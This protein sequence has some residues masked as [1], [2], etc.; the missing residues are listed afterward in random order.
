MAE[1]Q[2]DRVRVA[3]SQIGRGVFAQ[4][5]FRK[6][7]RIGE[8][9]GTISGSLQ[10]ATEYCIELDDTRSLE[11]HAPFRFLNHSCEPNC[12][13]CSWESSKPDVSDRVYLYTLRSIKPGEELTIDYAWPADAA[14]R[15]QCGV[16]ACR[17]W[18]VDIEELHKVE[19]PKRSKRLSKSGV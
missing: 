17:G 6:G 8:I 12:E 15:C 14:I 10:A 7:Q 13:I 4:R 9:C 1:Y 18:V 5:I 3:A 19:P 2:D 11:P 16:A